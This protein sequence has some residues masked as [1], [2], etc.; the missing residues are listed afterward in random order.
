MMTLGFWIDFIVP[1]LVV[2][3]FSFFGVRFL[4][5][6]NKQGLSWAWIFSGILF[7]VIWISYFIV[8]DFG[9]ELSCM[10]NL[11]GDKG[12][13]PSPGI[14]PGLRASVTL[15]GYMHIPIIL[16]GW[17]VCSLVAANKIYPP[18]SSGTIPSAR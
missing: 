17:V 3:I 7:L 5:K 9:H 13:V 1:L 18:R 6:Q 8:S 16:M 10:W 14:C 4:K 15:R 2:G 12:V 11:L